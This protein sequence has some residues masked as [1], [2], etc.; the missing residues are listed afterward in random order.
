MIN[1]EKVLCDVR[2]EQVRENNAEYMEAYVI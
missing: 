1:I 2:I